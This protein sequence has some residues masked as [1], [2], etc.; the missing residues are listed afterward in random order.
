MPTDMQLEVLKKYGLE[1]EAPSIIHYGVLGMKWGVRR[2]Q[3]TLDRLA[4]RKPAKSKRSTD[5]GLDNEVSKAKRRSD[6]RNRRTMSDKDLRGKIDR[7]K[8]ER[9]LTKLT[10]ED[11]N[12]VRTKIIQ[13]LS[14]AGYDVA[15]KTTTAAMTVIIRKLL[16]E[17]KVNITDIA[18]YLKPKK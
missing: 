10:N 3:R 1:H 9:E 13:L 8:L 14:D 18:A 4:G 17:E 15:K 6:K 16:K 11:L 2:D 12:P 7:L 5:S